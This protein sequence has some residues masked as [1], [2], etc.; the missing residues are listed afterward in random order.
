MKIGYSLGG[1]VADILDGKVNLKEV[2][3]II[4]PVTLNPLIPRD[5]E[6]MWYNYTVPRG[7]ISAKWRHLAREEAKVRE[8]VRELYISGKIFQPGLTV[9][10]RVKHKD[11]NWGDIK[12]E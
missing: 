11:T 7:I 9:G 3:V 12:N 5:W 2:E 4:T 10:F 6:A 1:C 8:L